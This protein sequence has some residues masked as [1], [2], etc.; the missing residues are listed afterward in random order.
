MDRI[1]LTK[2]I[3]VAMVLGFT[4]GALIHGFDW[5]ENAF[6][7]EFLVGG[8]FSLGGQIFIKTL[9][10]LVVPLVFV[11]LV[12]G[13]SSLAGGNNM[14]RI[15]L[16]TVALYLMTTAIA[17]TLALTVAN[18]INPGLG[19][20]MAE[21]MTFQAREA[22]PFTQVVLDIF[23]SNP[24]A[25]MAEGNMLQIIVFALLLGV[26]LTRAGDAGLALKASFD[27]WNEVIMQLVM[28]LMLAAPVGVF[29]LMVTLGAQLGFGA[30]LD[31]L[32]Y[33]LCVLLV[34]A[35]HFLITYPTLI[36]LLVRVSP[37]LF[38]QHMAPVMAFAF[39]T[40]S[41]G[42]TLPVTLETVKKRIGV[43]NEIASFVVPV[44]AT[45]NM[46]GTAIMQGVATVFIAQAFNVDIG[47]TG[48]LMVILTATMAS[49]GTAAVPG[50]GLITLA[51]VL[52]QV[53]LPVEGI[54][55]IIGVD[56][57]LDMTRTVV[58]VVGDATVS[59]VVA[60]SEGQF[61]DEIFAAESAR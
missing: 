2:Q 33:F 1:K 35:L 10:L 27:R 45:I 53:G 40:A 9:K 13:A 8:I 26:A 44:G 19:I 56:R 18:I 39:S 12:C 31:L 57:L 11:S 55:L 54:A 20:N 59:S 32:A 4:I 49:I 22:P 28:M 29:C 42:A 34:L 23:P 16:K 3:L 5:S 24:V 47:L 14:G 7:G 30:I 52:T 43:R 38:Y 41:S 51:L 58:N 25:A 46:D 17:I 36:K 48:Y 21:G 15:G 50:V 37:V 60:R 61:E 6:V